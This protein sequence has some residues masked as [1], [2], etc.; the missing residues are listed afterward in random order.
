MIEE[1]ML[2]PISDLR[3]WISNNEKAYIDKYNQLLQEAEEYKNRADECKKLKSKVDIINQ[4]FSSNVDF[5]KLLQYIGG[6]VSD[7]DNIKR[8]LSQISLGEVLGNEDIDTWIAN[9]K[10]SKIHCIEIKGKVV[11]ITLKD[12]DRIQDV[13]GYVNELYYLY[14]GVRDEYMYDRCMSKLIEKKIVDYDF[15]PIILKADYRNFAS[16]M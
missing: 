10:G 14:T 7:L 16:Q 15:K 11:N 6:S 12:P 13:T 8:H 4:R 9:T 5:L 1:M 3:E 2:C